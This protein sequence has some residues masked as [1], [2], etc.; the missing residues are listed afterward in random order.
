MNAA[1]LNLNAGTYAVTLDDDG[2]IARAMEILAD[3]LYKPSTVLESPDIVKKYLQLKMSKH[4]MQEVFS[5]IFLDAQHAVMEYREMFF[6]TLTQTS[7]YPR[8]VARIAL[9]LGA[10]A[11]IL[12]HNHP[13][14]NVTPSHADEHLTR[15]L[16]SALSL[17]DVRV[18]DH[19]I[20]GGGDS[21]SMAEKGLV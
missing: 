2:I 17:V 11:V 20:V 9:E 7:V 15:T 16:K 10:A 6:G 19:I 13:S 3:R 21:L 1:T 5:V 4:T 12:A 8:E 18:L 14:G